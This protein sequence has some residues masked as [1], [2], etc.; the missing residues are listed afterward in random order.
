MLVPAALALLVCCFSV[1]AA[2]SGDSSHKQNNPV[3]VLTSVSPTSGTVG[4]AAFT[5]TVKG[6]SFVTGSIIQWNGAALATAFVSITQLTAAIPASDLARSGAAQVTVVNPTPGGGTSSALTVTIRLPTYAL[7][8][9]GTLG[10]RH[11][12]GTAINA[13]GQ[14]T[15][16][17][18][19]A[20]TI[21]RAFVTQHGAMID[22]GA[23]YGEDINDSG[24]VTGGSSGSH[25][26]V[27]RNGATI[28]LGTLGAG[29]SH[30]V[31]IN[32]SGQVTGWAD[33]P[34]AV[35][36][37]GSRYS[38]VHAF[39]T[40]NDV[41]IDLGT[42]GGFSSE[43][44]AINDS[45]QVT[46]R[47][48]TTAGSTFHAF[49]TQNGVM[50]DLGTL[51]GLHSAGTAIN[52]SGQVTGS[53]ETANSGD[54][55]FVT[56]NGAMIDLGTLDGTFSAGTAINDSGQVTGYADM[57]G[58]RDAN[59]LHAFVTQNGVM[60]DLG[61]LGGIASQGTAINASGLVTGS[62]YTSGETDPR[63]FLYI[64]GQMRDLNALVD[65]NSPLASDVVLRFG[66]AISDTGYVLANGY[67]YATGESLHAFVLSP[68]PQPAQSP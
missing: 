5:L 51:G 4:G 6:S 42:L 13:S 14:V 63:A 33:A 56:Q 62:S 65:P 19:G 49:V 23:S 12:V 44:V 10:G 1:I 35:G 57:G 21:Y 67:N 68:A 20:D 15:G 18:E 41:M 29:C 50:I 39:V 2:C 53:S 27:T 9:L 32:A 45:G 66:I 24:Q 60:I 59:A 11:T 40:Q 61:T 52:A 30:G 43:G 31:A 47:S 55:A 16:R 25:A 17:S 8:D 58:E 26:F 46:G 36:T 7:T 22:L 48:Y 64:D 37:C 38:A 54:H 28:D 3:P 34:D